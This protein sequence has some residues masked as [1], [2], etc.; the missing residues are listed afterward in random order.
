MYQMRIIRCGNKGCHEELFRVKTNRFYSG[1][2]F[3]S[4]DAFAIGITCPKCKNFNLIKQEILTDES[5]VRGLLD[6]IG[7]RHYGKDGV[8]L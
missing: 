3:V 7:G 2:V 1:P 6:N 8:S 4:N 5:G